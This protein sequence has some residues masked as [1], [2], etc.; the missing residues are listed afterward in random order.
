MLRITFECFEWLEF[1]FQFLSNA[2]NH[3]RV[4][5][6]VR[7]WI[8]IL[9]LAFECFECLSNGYY[10]HSNAFNA[11][12]MVIICI[13]MLRIWFEWLDFGLECF[14]SFSN[15][16]T[17]FRIVRICIRKLLIHFK[18]YFLSN[19][20]SFDSNQLSNCC[21]HAYSQSAV[22]MPGLASKVLLK[23]TMN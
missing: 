21:I 9:E 16:S 10:L 13:R 3:F 17:T 23:S 8:Q 12:R 19:G 2:S 1:S 4:L 14:Q 7:I 20:Q 6:M 11:C 15:C 5:R 18:Q 22:T